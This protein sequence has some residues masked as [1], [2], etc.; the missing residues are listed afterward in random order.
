ML[1]CLTIFNQS[2]GTSERES[3]AFSHTSPTEFYA[4]TFR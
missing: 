2:D 3:G 1:A 4:C